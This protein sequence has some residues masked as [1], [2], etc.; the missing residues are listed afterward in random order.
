MLEQHLQAENERVA[1]AE[2]TAKSQGRPT[3][4]ICPMLSRHLQNERAELAAGTDGKLAALERRREHLVHIPRVESGAE[5]KSVGSRDEAS[6][7]QR[8]DILGLVAQIRSSP[9]EER[10]ALLEALPQ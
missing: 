8:Q 3:A 10:R 9:R 2:A 7:N 6:S 1:A 4:S 5:S